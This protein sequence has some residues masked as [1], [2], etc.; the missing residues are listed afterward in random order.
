MFWVVRVERLKL[1][2]VVFVIS[3]ASGMVREA[4]VVIRVILV[5]TVALEVLVSVPSWTE[6]VP[7]SYS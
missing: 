7:K 6:I 3:V 1:P 2:L 4:L 5:L